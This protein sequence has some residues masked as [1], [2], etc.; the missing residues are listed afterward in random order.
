MDQSSLRCLSSFS[1]FVHPRFFAR[2]IWIFFSLAE[3]TPSSLAT[4]SKEGKLLIEYQAIH[5]M[6]WRPGKPQLYRNQGNLGWLSSR[7]C[8]SFSLWDLQWIKK[9][10]KDTPTPI[11][12]LIISFLWDS[13]FWRRELIDFPLCFLV[14]SMGKDYVWEKGTLLRISIVAGQVDFQSYQKYKDRMVVKKETVLLSWNWNGGWIPK[15]GNVYCVLN[16]KTWFSNPKFKTVN[17]F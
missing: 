5:R 15:M 6:V 1:T 14:I 9:N 10:K 2:I 4:L 17:A 11:P 16:H 8:P 12:M 3:K 13:N 7:N